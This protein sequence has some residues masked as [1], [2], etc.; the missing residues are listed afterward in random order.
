MTPDLPHDADRRAFLGT[1]AAGTLTLAGAPLE[2]A[3]AMTSQPSDPWLAALRGKHKQVFDAQAFNSGFPLGYVF[4]YLTTMTAHYKLS[5]TDITAMLVVRNSAIGLLLTDPI[6]SRYKLGAMWNV[7]DPATKAPATRN[8]YINS[9]PGDIFNPSA[10]ADRLLARGVVFAVCGL[11]LRVM[12]SIAAS[13]AGVTPEA[14]FD[15]WTNGVL[16]G[17][18]IVPSGVLAVGRA[19]ESGCTYCFAG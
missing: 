16:P 2:S 1:V 13:A 8:I 7:I 6:W 11:A 14:A 18:H 12:S 4:N 15:E 19:Q 3:S 17:A 9:R 10:S 5:A